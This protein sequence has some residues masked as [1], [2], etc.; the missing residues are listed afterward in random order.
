[1][2]ITIFIVCFNEEIMLPKTVKHYKDRFS[3]AKI[4]ICDNYST[5]S[6]ISIAMS[7]G[8]QILQWKTTPDNFEFMLTHLK[9]NVWKSAC[10]WVIMCDMDEWLN[11]DEKQLIKE[12]ENGTTILSIHGYDINGNSESAILDDINLETLKKGIPNHYENKKLCFN[13]K[14]I[15]E[16]NYL[17]GS[18]HSNPVGQVK[19]SQTVYILKHMDW[20]GLPYKINKMKLRYERT[21][22]MRKYGLAVH[23]TDNIEE[24]TRQFNERLQKSKDLLFIEN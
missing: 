17:H 14:F 24:I 19:M 11:I 23:Y 9:N 6:S 12:Q 22:Q 15:K 2:E 8:C 16:L 7:L 13:T 3:N 5:D 21:F 10:G 18:H 20:L 1:M 4:I